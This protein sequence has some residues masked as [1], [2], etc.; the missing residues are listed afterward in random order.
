MPYICC[1]AGKIVPE[2]IDAI[3]GPSG[4][5]DAVTIGGTTFWFTKNPSASLKRHEWQHVVQA[6]R[7]APWWARWMPTRWKAWIGGPKYW[8]AYLAEHMAVGY[9][10]NKFEIE[11]RAKE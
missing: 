2:V 5:P 8:K 7:F 11:A 3:N 1:E 9:V 6:A 10:N 4:P